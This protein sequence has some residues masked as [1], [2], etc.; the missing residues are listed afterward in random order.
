MNS[1]GATRCSSISGP[2]ASYPR[3]ELSAKR[4]AKKV[5][6]FCS[7]DRNLSSKSLAGYFQ[8]KKRKYKVVKKANFIVEKK[9]LKKGLNR[10]AEGVHVR[11]C[12]SIV[13]LLNLGRCRSLFYPLALTTRRLPLLLL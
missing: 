9:E 7:A 1:R 4:A 8:S 6:D 3:S 11:L 12:R 5:I 10:P 2:Q 13:N